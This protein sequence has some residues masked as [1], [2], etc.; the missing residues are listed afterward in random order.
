MANEIRVSLHYKP[1][2]GRGWATDMKWWRVELY[3]EGHCV[4]HD[5]ICS[6]EKETAVKR[7]KSKHGIK[8]A[9]RKAS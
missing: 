8:P 9:N 5:E 7:F 3:K 4:L 2:A 6:V 1:K